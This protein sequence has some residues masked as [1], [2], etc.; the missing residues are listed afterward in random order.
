MDAGGRETQDDSMEGIGSVESG[1]ETEQ[2]PR[3]PVA[4][5]HTPEL[6][7]IGDSSKVR[8]ICFF[9]ELGWLAVVRHIEGQS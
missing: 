1:T 8:S 9:D 3:T 7:P 4:T 2:L 5:G 6:K